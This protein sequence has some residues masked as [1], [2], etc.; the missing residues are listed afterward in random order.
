MTLISHK[1]QGTLIFISVAGIISAIL[2]VFAS[3]LEAQW[4]DFLELRTLEAKAARTLQI[5][6]ILDRDSWHSRPLARQSLAQSVYQERFAS[7]LSPYEVYLIY[8]LR[9][10]LAS[11]EKALKKRE[12]SFLIFDMTPFSYLNAPTGKDNLRFGAVA[13]AWGTL[14][15]HWAAH[16]TFVVDTDGSAEP[17]YH[18]RKEWKGLS[19]DFRRAALTYCCGGFGAW[20]GR[21]EIWW[22]PGQYGS[23]SLSDA[24]PSLDAIGLRL[25]YKMF[26]FSAFHAF[27][28]RDNPQADSLKINRY[29]SGHRLDIHFHRNLILG[30]SELVMYGGPG[31]SV[32][33][34]YLNPLIS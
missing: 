14:G 24:A 16:S 27:L 21:N 9:R 23:L 12:S 25:R 2:F 22:G 34:S 15:N 3:K 10:E 33:A 6:G 31:E 18:N 20:V 5:R 4:L 1:L 28:Q 11:E 29:L 32:T 13:Q 19:G 26:E 7:G 30:F 8:H 17:H